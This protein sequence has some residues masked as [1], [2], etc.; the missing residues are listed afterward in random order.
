MATIPYVKIKD[1]TNETVQI[2]LEEVQVE[3]YHFV[4]FRGNDKFSMVDCE[5]DKCKYCATAKVLYDMG[6]DSLARNL[7]VK[8][9]W[10]LPILH[11]DQEKVLWASSKVIMD[12]YAFIL[13]D[14]KM[15]KVPDI[16]LQIKMRRIREYPDYTP[17]IFLIDGRVVP[18]GY[19]LD[20]RAKELNQC[21]SNCKIK[22]KDALDWLM[23]NQKE[24]AKF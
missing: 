24:L 12:A 4:K 6:E 16:E 9:R 10:G 15:D 7:F 13:A 17:S 1:L 19:I 5:G 20:L 21:R 2:L 18:V 22:F 23:K 14:P 3:Q 11:H 8:K